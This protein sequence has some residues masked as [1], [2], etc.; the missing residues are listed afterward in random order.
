M[1]AWREY[2]ATIS[3]E[4][5]IE[6]ARTQALSMLANGITAIR[7]HVD[8]HPGFPTRS[9]VALLSLRAEL[10][11][12]IDLEIVALASTFAS[13]ADIEAVLDLGI[14]LIGG[15]PHLADDPYAISIAC[16]TSRAARAGRRPA[17]RREPRWAGHPR[18]VRPHRPRPSARSPIFGRS[19]RPAGH[20]ERR[21]T[22]PSFA[23]VKAADIGVIALP[24]TNLYLQGWAHPVP[25]LA[26]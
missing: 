9:A 13:T 12:L 22:R 26:A 4:S 3:T 10:E 19:L 24:I 20:D 5:I 25:P 16:S 2:A 11:G 1:V 15:A 6:R 18:P 21:A 7:T 17:H 14:E 23:E 8:V